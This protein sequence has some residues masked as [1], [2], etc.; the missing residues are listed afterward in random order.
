MAV[1]RLR[2][3]EWLLENI[4]DT[5]L[6]ALGFTAIDLTDGSWTLT[7]PDS[8]VDTTTHSTGVNQ[9][10][11]N[12]LA[13]GSNDYAWSTST[14]QRAPRWTAPLYA[15]DASG[16]NVR[17]TSGDTYILQTV[18]EYVAP[19]DSFAT[20]IV[21]ASA[22]DGTATTSGGNKAQ[23]GYL[24]INATGN[25]RMG[26]FTGASNQLSTVDNNNHQNIAT[27]NH[28]GGRSQ[29]VSYV[30]IDSSGT[31]LA[32]SSRNSGMTYTNTTIDLNLM[33][34]LGVNGANTITAGED[35]KIKA[36]YRVVAFSLP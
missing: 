12:E 21:V 34:G 29:A 23:G 24:L 26:C 32:G 5:D 3:D 10:V 19:D 27:A 18:I 11:M 25:R 9:I 13:A 8:L 36:W 35:A 28:G 20:E 1:L 6:S 2:N 22:E 16:N 33:V 30:N 14:T 17:V 31:A 4:P 15:I 7:D